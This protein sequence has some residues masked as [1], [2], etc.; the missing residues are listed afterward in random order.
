MSTAKNAIRILSVWLYELH[1]KQIK[2]S[3][4]C[5]NIMWYFDTK[6]IFN[7]NKWKKMDESS[8]FHQYIHLKRLNS[9]YEKL[10]SWIKM[11]VKWMKVSYMSSIHMRVC[12][13]VSVWE[14]MNG[15]RAINTLSFLI[16]MQFSAI[17]ENHNKFTKYSMR[18]CV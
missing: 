7:G 18:R 8:W 11:P 1:T 9:R 10:F 6:L 5:E 2:S 13:C 14:R 4:W 12:K 17:P 16:R 3:T 15:S